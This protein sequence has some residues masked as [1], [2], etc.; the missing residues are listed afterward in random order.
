MNLKQKIVFPALGIIV[1]MLLVHSYRVL[2]EYNK[3]YEKTIPAGKLLGYETKID[4]IVAGE[5]CSCSSS[6]EKFAWI[7]W[8]GHEKE[9]KNLKYYRVVDSTAYYQITSWDYIFPGGKSKSIPR[10]LPKFISE[11]ITTSYKKRV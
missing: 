10:G 5:I 6:D 8:P 3:S 11:D 1:L 2:Y 4:K 9:L 7:E